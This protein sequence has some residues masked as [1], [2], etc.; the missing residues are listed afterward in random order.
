[1]KA[2][3]CPGPNPAIRTFEIFEIFERDCCVGRSGG[4]VRRV[5]GGVSVSS[6]PAQWFPSWCEAAVVVLD[7]IV[8]VPGGAVK[9]SR[10][11]HI[12]NAQQQRPLNK[13]ANQARRSVASVGK[14][15][16][17]DR[18]SVPINGDGRAV[19]DDVGGVGHRCNAGHAQFARHD[20]RVAAHRPNIDHDSGR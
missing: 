2:A 20:H 6:Q 4:V 18:A 14:C 10:E 19:R 13:V 16:D 1:M 8:R 12:D 17:G 3:S 9:R 7:P 5:C 11:Q 15:H